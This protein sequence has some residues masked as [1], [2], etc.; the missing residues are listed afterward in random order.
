MQRCRSRCRLGAEV[1]QG[2]QRYRFT[3]YRGA[4]VVQSSRWKNADVQE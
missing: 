2:M 4:D 1:V 3:S